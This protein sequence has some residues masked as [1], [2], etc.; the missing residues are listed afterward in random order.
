MYNT[1]HTTLEDGIFIITINRSEK[2]NALNKNVIEELGRALNEVYNNDEIKTAIITG[3]GEKAFVAGADITEFLSLSKEEGSALAQ[4]G[5]KNVFDKI[6]HSPKPIAAA[7]NGFALG[8]GCELAMA[9]H[10]R[11]AAANGKF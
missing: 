1:I 8:G 5:R 2:M 4:K 11:I 3:A 6:E 9:C 10:F 7:V